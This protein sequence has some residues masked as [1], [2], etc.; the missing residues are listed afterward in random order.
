MQRRLFL[1]LPL[2]T[3]ALAFSAAPLAGSDGSTAVSPQKGI[4]VKAGQ[5]RSNKPFKWLD[6][7]FH[8]KV[9]GQDNE[10]RFVI[11][12]TLRPEKVGPPLHLHTDC[13]EWFFVIDGEFKFQVGDETLRLKA[14]DSLT[15]LKDTPHAFVKTSEGMARMI[16]MHQPAG[17]MEEYFRTV[18]QLPDQSIEGRRAYAE[19]HGMRILGQ[20]LKA[21]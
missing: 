8:V 7:T 13:D 6:A 5:D 16:V 20:P 17:K 2:L 15:V 19:K 14:G 4:L 9:S 11:F 3:P 18:T 1:Q 21:D 12:D 10:G